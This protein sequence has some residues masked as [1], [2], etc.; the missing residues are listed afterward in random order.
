MKILT[1]FL[2]CIPLLICTSASFCME[3]K[4]K[5]SDDKSERS[6]KPKKRRKTEAQATEEL[7][8]ATGESIQDLAKLPTIND[9]ANVNARDGRGLSSL[10]LAI[11]A[12]NLN[13]IT[14]LANDGA[15]INIRDLKA[16]EEVELGDFK[17]PP[18]Y[19]GINK[20]FLTPLEFLLVT[21]ITIHPLESRTRTTA[22][23]LIE[24]GA[25]LNPAGAYFT[26]LHAL[27]T[28]PGPASYVDLLIQRGANPNLVNSRGFPPLFFNARYPNSDG[29]ATL[30]RHGANAKFK[31]RL[32]SKDGKETHLEMNGEHSLLDVLLNVCT[33]GRVKH[34]PLDDLLNVC[35]GGRV[36][37]SSS[38][39]VTYDTIFELSSDV[40]QFIY[41]LLMYGSEL[42]DY[43][44]PSLRLVMNYPIMKRLIDPIIQALTENNN[45]TVF[46]ELNKLVNKPL[47]ARQVQE[48]FL[49]SVGRGNAEVVKFVLDNFGSKFDK[50]TRDTAV[51]RAAQIGHLDILEFLVASLNPDQIARNVAFRLA[52]RTEEI[53][54]MAFL[55]ETGI[56]P[57]ILDDALNEAVIWGQ[58]PVVAFFNE[59]EYITVERRQELLV[60]AARYGQAAI[61]EFL[62][63]E[64]MP[65][66]IIYDAVFQASLQ[67]HVNVLRTLLPHVP[68]F[69][70]RN[71]GLHIRYALE[72][73]PFSNEQRASY[74]EVFRELV[75][76]QRTR[77]A[78]LGL[79]RIFQG[80]REEGQLPLPNLPQEIFAHITQLARN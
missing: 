12:L 19:Q 75:R 79:E 3:E 54:T 2:L 26:P 47:D 56:T 6:S 25:N 71:A 10:H 33:R 57:E 1:K 30:L 11:V 49:F 28:L 62:Y 52:G 44:R 51:I 42:Q 36:R 74:E 58:L 72:N 15:D 43:N 9:N 45:D 32:K 38:N 7:V 8:E 76:H 66:E 23:K 27:A 34:I 64:S 78:A 59:D 22:E 67:G 48:Y 37:H 20:S 50:Q 41:L 80:E 31:V 55:Y 39:V 24:L 35:T 46:E 40:V 53:G 70:A 68:F 16:Q 63:R 77:A 73:E 18:W 14:L 13:K 4:R 65:P 29:A 69:N 61:V 5:E 17:N 21:F 60:R